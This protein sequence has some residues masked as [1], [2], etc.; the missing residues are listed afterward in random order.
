MKMNG[1]QSSFVNYLKDCF[2]LKRIR[3][4]IKDIQLNP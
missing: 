3:S 2:G 4:T 1:E